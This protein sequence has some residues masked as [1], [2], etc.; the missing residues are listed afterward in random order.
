M[1]SNLLKQH[2]Q[3]QKTQSISVLVFRGDQILAKEHINADDESLYD[4]A[5][6]TKVFLTTYLCMY[7]DTQKK[8]R[9]NNLLSYYLPQFKNTSYERITIGHL[10]THTS[11]IQAWVPAYLK[12][13]K[14]DDFLTEL[15][16]IPL[17]EKIGHQR[18]YSDLGF[19][20]L[21]EILRKIIQSDPIVFW[22]KNFEALKASMQFCPKKNIISSSKG[23]PFEYQFARKIIPDLG[24]DEVQLNQFNWRKYPLRGEVNDGNCFHL[25]QGKSFHAGLFSN[26]SSLFSMMKLLGRKNYLWDPDLTKFYRDKKIA[27]SSHG[28]LTDPLLL[29]LK[30]N[31]KDWVGHHGFTGCSFLYHLEKELGIVVLSNRQFFG[32]KGDHYP[33]WKYLILEIQKIYF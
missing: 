10:L 29:G 8:L 18:I 24:W 30:A 9:K 16:K 4:I 17:V 32:L 23:N 21:G 7:L 13:R 12:Y 26:L 31:S 14:L 6:M 5:S 15:P 27:G 20:L 25:Y 19:M 11:G 22:E 1:L 33:D 28:F 3:D 2:V